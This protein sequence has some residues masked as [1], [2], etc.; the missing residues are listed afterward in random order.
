M[1]NKENYL[2]YEY[3]C[4]NKHNTDLNHIT[5]HWSVIPDTVLIESGYFKSENE[6][7]LKRKHNNQILKEYG[8]DGIS[9]ETINDNNIYHGLQ[10]KLWNYTICANDIGTFMS[11]IF[12][13]FSNESKGFLYHTSKLEKTLKNDIIN[14]NKIYEI[15]TDNPFIVYD[16]NIN[17]ETINKEYILRPYQLEAIEKLNNN[18]TGIKSLIL[19]CGTGKTTIFCEY[20]K[21]NC[22]DNIFIFSPL[23]MLTEQN[24]DNLIDYLPS[25]N[26]ILVDVNGTRDFQFI[27]E[28]L[29]KKTIYS[30]TFKSADEIISKIFNENNEIKLSDNTILIIDEAHNIL[31]LNNILNLINKFNKVLLVTATPPAQLDDIIPN[32]TIYRYSFNDAIKDNYICDYKV[33]LPYI[34][35]NNI[36]IDQPE[37]LFELDENI[38]KKSLFL[39]NGLLRT[40]SRRTIVYLKNKDECDIYKNTLKDVMDKYHYYNVNIDIITSDVS[41][42]ERIKIL[43]NFEKD[44]E[45]EMI[46]IILSIRILDEGINIVKCDSIYLT[47]FGNK[48]NDIRTT[49]RFLRANRKDNTN[50]NKIANIFIWCEDINKCL[51][52]FQMLKCNDINFNKKIKVYDNNYGSYYLNNNILSNINKYNINNSIIEQIN[53]NCLTEEEIWN[54]K[55]DILFNYCEINNKIP[56]QKT[57]HNNIK[58][59]KWYM[60]QKLKLNEIKNITENNIYIELIKNIVIKKDLNK[61][62]NLYLNKNL[63]KQTIFDTKFICYKCNYLTNRFSDI[64]KHLNRK[65]PCLTR[66]EVMQLSDDHILVKTLLPY[67]NNACVIEDNDIKHLC[68]SSILYQN[69]NEIFTEIINVDKNKCKTCKYC[70]CNFDKIFYLKKHM[71]LNCFYNEFTKRNNNDI[72]HSNNIL[73]NNLNNNN[74]TISNNNNNITISNNNNN[75]TTNNN[76]TNNITLYVE[77]KQPI[78][79]EESWDLSNINND[80]RS[81]ILT[82]KYMYKDLLYNILKNDINNNVIINSDKKTGIV[83]MN[84]NDKYILMNS[85]KIIEKTIDKLHDNLTSMNIESKD[86]RDNMVYRSIRNNINDF[87]KICHNTSENELNNIIN[88]VLTDVYY[89]NK[90]IA[91]KLSN[92]TIN[93]DTNEKSEENNITDKINYYKKIYK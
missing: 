61:Y 74:I 18:W 73:N 47:Y 11:V 13:R 70:N 55:K 3:Y 44:E 46:K 20:L 25:Y 93:K 77:V 8:L 51:D 45:I 5:Y 87:H 30:C 9:I 60:I 76:T 33:Y 39:L 38:C 43:N 34:E 10:M 14:G 41:K 4:I 58:I 19:P 32:S 6:L 37:E 82:S 57:I 29:N 86:E 65:N 85:E 67:Y 15:K 24:L 71:L 81:S 22:F 42:I 72:I 28:N 1:S 50:P 7:R 21:Q 79:F 64:I 89:D 16:N 27:Q 69:K 88:N 2:K 31:N 62:L 90:H 56:L 53:I 63:N 84:H 23:T 49:Q 54:N 35:N 17:L 12:N 78:P 66:I 92:D 48:T 52:S 83:Y 68:N 75:N 36:V 40:G 91:S 59:G 26:H 80:Q